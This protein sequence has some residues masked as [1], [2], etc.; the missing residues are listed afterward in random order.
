M[1]MVINCHH[2]GSLSIF[3]FNVS[4][5]H[6]FRCLAAVLGQNLPQIQNFHKVGGDIDLVGSRKDLRLQIRSLGTF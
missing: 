5:I 1:F 3:F 6:I 2:G 4:K